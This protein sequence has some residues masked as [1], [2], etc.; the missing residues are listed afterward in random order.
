M[1][2]VTHTHTITQSPINITQSALDKILIERDEAAAIS[3]VK[4]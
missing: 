2:G 3:Y 1:C 4:V